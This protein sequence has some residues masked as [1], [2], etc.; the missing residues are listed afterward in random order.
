M[1]DLGV[2]RR[3][4]LWVESSKNMGQNLVSRYLLWLI[5]R[6]LQIFTGHLYRPLLGPTKS[7]LI[8]VRDERRVKVELSELERKHRLLIG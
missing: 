7:Q 2:D 8:C 4:I 5:P 6:N 1:V 3:P